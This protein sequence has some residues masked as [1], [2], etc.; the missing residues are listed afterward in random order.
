[1]RAQQLYT[2][3]T[4]NLL[5][6]ITDEGDK[7]EAAIE[8]Q[9]EAEFDPMDP[10]LLLK[11]QAMLAE[12]AKQAPAALA[13]KNAKK[14]VAPKKAAEP[15]QEHVYDNLFD[16]SDVQISF[17]PRI[18]LQEVKD[19]PQDTIVDAGDEVSSNFLARIVDGGNNA[20]KSLYMATAE[21][22]VELS[23]AKK[24]QEELLDA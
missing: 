3:S 16:D 6:S 9:N 7:A 13:Q 11:Q 17:I 21:G 12:K 24:D 19:E 23:Q 8:S 10:K 1:L 5:A 15:V 20:E 18:N 4:H 14:A 22:E 2:A